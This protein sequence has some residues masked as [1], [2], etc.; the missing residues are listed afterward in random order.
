V[1]SFIIHANSRVSAKD[2]EGHNMCSY[3]YGFSNYVSEAANLLARVYVTQ[4]LKI[5][6]YSR[7]LS[8][9]WF[10]FI[11]TSPNN[12]VPF[13]DIVRTRNDVCNIC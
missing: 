4:P 11:E 13:F 9:I 7:M 10:Y 6:F 12:S 2:M 8:L 3:R 1:L 5:R